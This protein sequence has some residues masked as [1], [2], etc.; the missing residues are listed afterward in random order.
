MNGKKLLNGKL[1]TRRIQRARR[2]RNCRK[3]EPSR[4]NDLV[5]AG[6]Y[7]RCR[8]GKMGSIMRGASLCWLFV[9]GVL[10]CV[11]ALPNIFALRGTRLPSHPRTPLTTVRCRLHLPA[12]STSRATTPISN[13]LSSIPTGSPPS[14]PPPKAP[15]I[16][17]STP[18]ARPTVAQRRQ[19]RRSRVR[20]FA[21][22]CCAK[23]DAWDGR[24]L[25]QRRLPAELD[26]QRHGIA[27]LKVRNSHMGTTDQ[28]AGIQKWLRLLAARVREYF[29]GRDRARKRRLEQPHVLGR[30]CRCRP[31]HRR[32]RRQRVSVG[33]RNL[34]HGRQ[35][36]SA[37]RLA[38]R[39]NDPRRNGS[40]L[41]LY[42]LG[43]LVM[44]AELGAANGSISTPLNNGA[45]HRLVKFS[46]A[47]RR[48]LDHRKAHRGP[49][50][51]PRDS[52]WY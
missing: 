21:A 38:H 24:C 34:S 33:H 25:A 6:K 30:S 47:A 44:L 13:T 31:G 45:I 22:R 19:P 12:P 3:T 35:R 15:L 1:C 39:R 29:D 46:I 17:A 51:H 18:H 37:G 42:A 52:D 28:D 23:A 10:A 11:P 32:Q 48:I 50:E 7:K 9:A 41:Q 43:P 36:H 26:A 5:E 27:Y 20:L 8:R 2:H 49:A 16:S 4:S 40:T 14:T